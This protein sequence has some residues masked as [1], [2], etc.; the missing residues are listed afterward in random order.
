MIFFWMKKHETCLTTRAIQ[1]YE[2]WKTMRLIRLSFVEFYICH[3]KM[4]K[5]ALLLFVQ[6]SVR[7]RHIQQRFV[8]KNCFT[9]EENF[10]NAANC[11]TSCLHNELQRKLCLWSS[12]GLS[13]LFSVHLWPVTHRQPRRL[14]RRRRLPACSLFSIWD[15]G[16]WN[17]KF[18]YHW[19]RSKLLCIPCLHQVNTYCNQKPFLV[20]F[21][22]LI[23][24]KAV[25]RL[26]YS[27][28]TSDT[29]WKNSFFGNFV[30][31]PL[32]I[33]N[34]WKETGTCGKN[35]KLSVT[36]RTKT[37]SGWTCFYTR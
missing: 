35:E 9:H 3:W 10:T 23:F 5:N 29:K 36:N 21:L 28:T 25:S 30:L 17:T 33:R 34:E 26:E 22:G 14:K 6:T 18:D 13:S 15:S 20:F 1:K 24:A 12:I 37:H 16:F 7:R 2:L 4:L 32:S 11:G 8:Y 19:F 31:A 27:T